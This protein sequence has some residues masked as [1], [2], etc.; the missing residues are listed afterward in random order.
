MLSALMLALALPAYAAQQTLALNWKAETQFGGFYAAQYSKAFERRH[1]DVNITEGGSGTP[2]VQILAAGRVNYAIV[3]GDEIAIA[4][5][6]GADDVV[7]LFAVYQTNPQCIMTHAERGFAKIDDVLQNDGTLLWQAGLPYAQYFRKKYAP[8]KVRSAPYLGGIGQFQHDPQTSQQC[9]ITSEPLTA[10]KAGIK[11][12]AFLVADSG[13]NPYTT[14]LATTRNYLQ[15]HPDEV[16]AMVAAV[17]EGW[18]NYLKDPAATNVQMA[19]LNKAVSLDNLNAG[20]KAQQS[21]IQATPNGK[22]GAM[23][24]ARWQQLVEQLQQL[25]VIHKPVAADKLF[26]DL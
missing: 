11:V 5:D 4:H 13:Y 20:A 25:G 2:T 14:V 23:T 16:R 22:L 21:L 10:E 15:Q 26:V 17:R 8:I 18:S 3:S 9:F 24:T 1:L 12:K 7:A 19:T 6:R